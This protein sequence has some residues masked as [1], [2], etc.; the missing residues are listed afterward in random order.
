MKRRH[1]LEPLGLLL[2]RDPALRVPESVTTSPIPARDWEAAV[3]TSI[4]ARARPVRLDRG[5][6]LVR[7]ATATWAQELSLLSDAI[8]AQLRGRGIDVSQLRFKVGPVDAPERPPTRTEVRTSP[9]AVP[10]PASLGAAVALVDDPELRDAIAHAAAKNLGW[11]ATLPPAAHGGS[12][13]RDGSPASHLDPHFTMAAR[14]LSASAFR[15]DWRFF[16]GKSHPPGTLPKIHGA[17]IA[18]KAD[19]GV[20]WIP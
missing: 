19:E 15:L 8:L 14:S 12:G 11:Q 3:G 4:A 1:G 17:R 5:V 6:L 18:T 9:P 20:S 7:A 10:L 16:S 13:A 2:S